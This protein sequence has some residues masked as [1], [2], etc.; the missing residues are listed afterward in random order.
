M[1]IV[2]GYMRANAPPEDDLVHARQLADQMAVALS[3]SSLIDELD[4]LNWGTLKALARTVDAKSAWTAGHSERVLELSMRIADPLGLSPQERQILHRGAL[5]HDIGKVG[6]PNR[7]LDKP[8]RL[9]SEEFDLIKLHPGIGARILEPIKAYEE[10]IP[11]VHQHHE[12]FDGT[13]YPLGLSGETIHLG[14]RILTVADVFDA[15]L[16][17]RPYRIGLALDDVVNT[18]KQ[19]EG[20]QFDPAVVK[21]FLSVLWTDDGILDIWESPSSLERQG[22]QSCG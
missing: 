16:S 13:G 2:M 14:A 19:G 4:Q 5:L 1:T 9:S 11:L 17:N 15:M 8:S 10:V 22:M 18:I 21:A 7:V 12:R 6:I 20:K 3:N